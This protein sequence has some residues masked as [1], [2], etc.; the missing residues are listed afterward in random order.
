MERSSEIFI[1]QYKQK[2]QKD[3]SEISREFG[4]HWKVLKSWLHCLVYTRNLCAH[5]GRLWNR[6]LAIRP[7]IPRKAKEWHTPFLIDNTKVFAILSITNY[8]TKI[9][10]PEADLK[11]KIVGIFK[12]YPHVGIHK[13]G[14]VQ[15]WK[16]HEIWK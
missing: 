16:S 2:H 14:F 10:S 15:G 5:H 7:L 8:L 6:T 9:L 3:Q 13:M 1:Q 12:D 4:V 11:G